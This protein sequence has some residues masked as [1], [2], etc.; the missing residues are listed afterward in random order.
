VY[1]DPL[2]YL[3]WKGELHTAVQNHIVYGNQYDPNGDINTMG[4]LFGLEPSPCGRYFSTEVKMNYSEAAKEYMGTKSG[5]VDLVDKETGELWEIK[6]N[7]DKTGVTQALHDV[8]GY[9]MKGNTYNPRDLRDLT[10]T[11]GVKGVVPLTPFAY[12]AAFFEYYAIVYCSPEEGVIVYTYNSYVN[13]DEALLALV[14]IAL[15]L[16]GIHLPTILTQV[17]SLSFA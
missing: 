2:G 3:A 5:R 4:I 9:T 16:Y 13:Y 12:Q 10:P 14:L 15:G 11:I 17:P 7:N 1:V 6:P 8:I